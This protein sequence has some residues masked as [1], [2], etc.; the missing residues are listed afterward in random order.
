MWAHAVRP[1]KIKG[2]SHRSDGFSHKVVE[3]QFIEGATFNLTIGLIPGL[4]IGLILGPVN[5]LIFGLKADVRKRIYPNE[6][7]WIS[8]N[9]TILICVALIIFTLVLYFL[10]SYALPL[11]VTRRIKNLIIAGVAPFPL[12]F[13]FLYGGGLAC[14]QHFA[15]RVVL[16]RAKLI[17]WNFG[18][19]F[20]QAE[21]RLFV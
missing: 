20:Q 4:M 18:T 13:G 1:H 11:F 12:L 16:Y 2:F 8:F 15:L 6:G 5:G 7:I 14:I 21:D 9:N 3:S 19:F 10:L 17:P